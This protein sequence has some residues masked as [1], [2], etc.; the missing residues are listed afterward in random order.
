LAV[1]TPTT[2]A[3]CRRHFRIFDQLVYINSCSQGALSDVVRQAY[4]DYLHDW[5]E[6]GA[7]WEYWIE[8][9]E[10][11]RGA[12]ARLVNANPGDV[13]VTTSVSAGVS[14]IATGIDVTARPRI[15][16]T[17]LEFPTIGQIWHAQQARGAEIVHVPAVDGELSL[18]RLQKVV[19][20]RTALVSVTSVCYRNGVRLPVDEIVRIAKERGALVL[21]DAYQAVGTYPIDVENLGVDFVTGGALKYLL[22][23]AGVA[24]LWSRH[25]LIERLK[26]LVTGWFADANVFDMDVSDYSPSQTARRFESGT[27]PIPAIYAAI[28]GMAL[29]EEIGVSR[30]HEHVQRLNDHLIAGADELGCALATP[31]E[32]EKHGALICIRASDAPALVA[33]LASDGIVTSERD[34]NLRVSAHCYN[35]IDDVEAVL[36]SLARNR[37]LL[38]S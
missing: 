14:A 12:F 27:P 18:E 32:H 6:R 25:D 37:H 9:A 34:G 36:A 35:T 22:G 28:G 4:E 19:N 29:I 24:F 23:S 26:P 13:A 31:R 16:V 3:D 5:D 21:L 38:L 33:S 17:D 10:T 20:E 1:E 7:P 2:P 11:A 8:R 30:I 15:V